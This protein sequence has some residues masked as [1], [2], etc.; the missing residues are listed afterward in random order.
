MRKIPN[1][2]NKTQN[3]I[4]NTKY[5]I[6]NTKINKSI[7]YSLQPKLYDGDYSQIDFHGL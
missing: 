6:R 7:F 4:R 2:V 3:E 1:I 5:E